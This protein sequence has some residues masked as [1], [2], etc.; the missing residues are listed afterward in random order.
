MYRRD[1]SSLAVRRRRGLKPP[2]WAA[3]GPP[4]IPSGA[5]F[6]LRAFEDL[7]GCRLV[8]PSA[9]WLGPISYR[10]IVWYLERLGLRHGPE[11]DACVMIIRRLD[12]AFRSLQ[13]E[14]VEKEG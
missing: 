2:P 1:E 10:D 13:N 7:S 6:L 5:E 8:D 9:G 3:D 12:G 11:L 4:P 14:V